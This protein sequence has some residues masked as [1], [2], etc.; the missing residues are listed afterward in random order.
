MEDRPLEEEEW[1]KITRMGVRQERRKKRPR[2][3]FKEG[4]RVPFEN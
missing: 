4:K 2:F 3:L 1:M